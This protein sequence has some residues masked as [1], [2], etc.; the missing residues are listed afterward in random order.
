MLPKLGKKGKKKGVHTPSMGSLPPKMEE[1]ARGTQ[2]NPDVMDRNQPAPADTLPPSVPKANANEDAGGG[3]IDSVRFKT[4]GV[5]CL[6]PCLRRK[7]PRRRCKF[8]LKRMR[9]P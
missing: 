6:N 5:W 2:N 9:R 3:E 7:I 4:K 1:T 8:P